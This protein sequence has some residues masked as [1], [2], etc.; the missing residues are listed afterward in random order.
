[1]QN[2]KD[3]Q[4]RHVHSQKQID[5]MNTSLLRSL[6]NSDHDKTTLNYELKR[7]QHLDRVKVS[8]AKDKFYNPDIS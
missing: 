7:M 2:I 4:K 3:H 1:M 5:E 8:Y 6:K